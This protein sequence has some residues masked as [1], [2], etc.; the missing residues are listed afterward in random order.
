[1]P[2][3]LLPLRSNPIVLKPTSVINLRNADARVSGIICTQGYCNIVLT[4]TNN[5]CLQI[6]D[7]GE[8]LYT[9]GPP[10]IEFNKPVSLTIDSANDLYICSRS[11]IKD[12]SQGTAQWRSSHVIFN[13]TK[14]GS[15]K[16]VGYRSFP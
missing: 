6:V 7:E 10:E 12:G 13:K 9:I 3:G 1:M 8:I 5:Q 15:R 4:D 14:K 11:R 2:R 16:A